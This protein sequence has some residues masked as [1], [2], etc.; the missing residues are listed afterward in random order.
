MSTLVWCLLLRP[1]YFITYCCMWTSTL[2]SSWLDG[3]SHSCGLPLNPDLPFPTPSMSC[4]WSWGVSR[5]QEESKSPYNS[6]LPT[7][8]SFSQFSM[9]II[10]FYSYFSCWKVLFSPM[11]F[12]HSPPWFQ[13]TPALLRARPCLLP[14]CVLT[15]QPRQGRV[16]W[17]RLCSWCIVFA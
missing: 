16:L 4:G 3:S 6:F 11:A 10:L 15:A 5:T 1:R 7:E 2:D 9:K 8:C 13:P 14:Q 17:S 12:L